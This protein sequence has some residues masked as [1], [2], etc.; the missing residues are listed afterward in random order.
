MILEPYANI[1]SKDEDG[2][3]PLAIAALEGHAE[4][5][6]F[7]LSLN[8][9]DNTRAHPNAC[10]CNE[11]TP[12][13]N[14]IYGSHLKCVE[15]LCEYGGMEGRPIVLENG[16]SDDEDHDLSSDEEALT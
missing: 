9:D 16:S 6:R 13:D 4:V 15:L 11:H 8:S 14:A 1:D 12:L 7:L 3:T 10:D 5:V 2:Y